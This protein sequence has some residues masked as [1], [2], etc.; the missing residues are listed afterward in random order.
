MAFSPDGWSVAWCGSD[1]A[2]KVWE[3]RTGEIHTLRGHTSW[4]HGVAYSPDGK[5]I[6]SGSQDGTVKIWETPALALPREAVADPG[7]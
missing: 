3:E 6:A 1:S 7:K 5:F 4:V 2:V